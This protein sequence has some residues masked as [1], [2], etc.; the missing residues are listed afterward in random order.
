MSLPGSPRCHGTRACACLFALSVLLVPEISANVGESSAKPGLIESIIV[1][2]ESV[3]VSQPVQLP[4]GTRMITFLLGEFAD[5][6]SGLM[7]VKLDGVDLDWVP[8]R[9]AQAFAY[10][11]LPPGEYVFRVCSLSAAEDCGAEASVA[12]S[13]P[14]RVW[15]TLL[16]R[17]LILLGFIAAAVGTAFWYTLEQRR[18]IS[19]LR[20]DLEQ[21]GADLEIARKE[22]LE[23]LAEK[24]LV[25][26]QSARILNIAKITKRR[27]ND[28]IHEFRTPLALMIDPLTAATDGTYEDLDPQLR[29]RLVKA[30]DNTE[31]LSVLIDQLLDL[32]KLES[33]KMQLRAREDDIVAFLRY[34]T[35]VLSSEAERC[36]L[37]LLFQSQ[38]ES[39]QAY[40]D[41]S[42]LEKIVLNLVSNAIKATDTGGKILVELRCNLRNTHL[43]ISIRDTGRG[44]EPEY[45]PQIFDRFYRA[46]GSDAPYP[47]G[48][49]IGLALVRELTQLHRGEV[50]AESSVGFGTTFTIVLPLGRDHLRDDEV[51][52][53]DAT[54]ESPWQGASRRLVLMLPP[55]MENGPVI[56]PVPTNGDLPS[57]LVVEDNPDMRELLVRR[58]QKTF[59]VSEAPNGVK[60]FESV[61]QSRPDA[62]LTDLVMAD[63]DGISFCR[64]LKTDERFHD[65][66]VVVLTAR[67]NLESRMDGL[68]AGAD[69]YLTKPCS[70]DELITTIRNLIRS[71]EVM[72]KHYSE[73][74]V[75]QPTNVV[76]PSADALFL[77][78][79]HEVVEE[80]IADEQF[81]VEAMARRLSVSR[82]QLKRKL[83]VLTGEAPVA[84]LRSRRLERAASLLRQR[85][86]NVNEIAYQ[87]GFQNM[88]YFTKCFRER[89]G[90]TPSTFAA[91]F[92]KPSEQS[93]GEAE[94]VGSS[95]DGVSGEPVGT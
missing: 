22:N 24:R 32:A 49:G 4:R 45:L 38:L 59:R 27:F 48:V 68:H 37:T 51:D 70:P 47:G 55:R 76:V 31:R 64:L 5:D 40:F 50:R 43:E 90:K 14:Y 13:V 42:L 72:R 8:A 92:P 79:V 60:A 69:A 71:R 46:E 82:S 58:L 11:A 26:H 85:A 61:R 73:E 25:E 80:H 84:F 15:E 23:I 65:I 87:V 33:H 95:G 74:V 35:Q 66:P 6:S 91:S 10:H 30:K 57:V 7:H 53:S 16:F 81:S 18:T 41:A 21:R 44:M 20:E 63:M 94:G 12:I 3:V 54:A 17:I 39:L 56:A 67:A 19:A 88:S 1:G 28:I 75:L 78:R 29:R 36:H 83:R 52:T 9:A 93:S 62:V 77:K 86:G 34:L 2:T 89:F